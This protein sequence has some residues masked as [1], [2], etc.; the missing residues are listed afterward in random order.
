MAFR[1]LLVPLLA[2]VVAATGHAQGSKVGFRDDHV[3][4]VGG[5][6]FF[7]IGLY[8]CAEEFEDPTDK[9]LRE[10]R[11][12]GFST[13]GYYRWGQPGWQ[14]EL[15]RTDRA[16]LKVW[17]RGYN[18][19][20]IESPAIEKA[21][22][23]QVRQT[24]SSTALLFWEFQDE[25]ILNKVPVEASRKGYELVKREDPHH[26]LLVVEWPGAVERMHLW[27][28]IGD[29]FA[30]DLYPIP[31]ERKYGRLPNHDI[32]QMRDYIAAIR[33][34]HGDRPILL[35]LQAWAWEPLKDG[36]K[37][38]PTPRES[39]FMAYQSVI[40][41]AWDPLLRPVPLH[42]AQLGV[43]SLLGGERPAGAEGRVREVLAAQPPIL[44]PVPRVL[45]GAIP[46][47]EN[48]C[49]ARGAGRQ[50]HRRQ[51]GYRA[52]HPAIRRRPV[53]D[54]GE[55]EPKRSASNVSVTCRG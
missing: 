27:K 49:P 11:D 55:P 14:K 52:C 40:H 36:E 24:R 43:R 26:P 39:R 25:P 5:K 1:L 7:P 15:E 3:I 31:R 32:T 45:P 23:E 37:G 17:I 38:Y 9:L 10:L 2:V 19:L 22:I 53:P 46:G 12:Y 30:T 51:P 8:Y 48:L 50:V 33:K 44:G 6:L 29:I 41:G 34:A 28:G 21:V 47:D 16:G 4:L 42:Q 35:V 13:L 54:C 18:G 20:A